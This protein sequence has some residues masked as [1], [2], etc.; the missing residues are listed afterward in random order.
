[1]VSSDKKSIDTH[2]LDCF[3]S[4]FS[5]G[6][7]LAE[8]GR[9]AGKQERMESV[10]FPRGILKISRWSWQLLWEEFKTL[11]GWARVAGLLL[12]SNHGTAFDYCRVQRP[13]QTP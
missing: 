11:T 10:E 6:L 1:M 9:Q 13:S 5:N 7:G 2:V 8:A 4:S 12:S 3:N